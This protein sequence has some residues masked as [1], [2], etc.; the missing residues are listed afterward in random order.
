MRGERNNI[1]NHPRWSEY[2]TRAS[3]P[4]LE[5]SRVVSYI[6]RGVTIGP[7]T[8]VVGIVSCMGDSTATADQQNY[9]FYQLWCMWYPPIILLITRGEHDTVRGVRHFHTRT[10]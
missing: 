6:R 7:S 9:A 10:A 4:P 5:I 1:D 3:P 2:R 8:T